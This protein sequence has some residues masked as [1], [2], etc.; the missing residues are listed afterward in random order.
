VEQE[1]NLSQIF[2]RKSIS[3]S[4]THRQSYHLIQIKQGS[5]TWCPWA[6]SRPQR[7]YRSPAGLF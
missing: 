3:R 4:T 2:N 1:M 7:P 5:P 6:L